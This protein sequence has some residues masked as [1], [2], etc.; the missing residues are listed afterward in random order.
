M[1]AGILVVLQ[2]SLLILIKYILSYLILSYLIL[3]YLILSYLILSYLILSYLILS[4]LILSYPIIHIAHTCGRFIVWLTVIC[5][6][7]FYLLCLHG[8]PFK[9]CNTQTR[10]TSPVRGFANN[11]FPKNPRLLWKWV[12]GSR[13][14]WNFL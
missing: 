2:V 11:C 4:Y 12:G 3:S 6:S 8:Y 1:F 5:L 7:S 13:S 14:H 10:C 9:I